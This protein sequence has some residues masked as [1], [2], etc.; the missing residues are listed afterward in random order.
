MKILAVIPVINLWNQFTEQCI[1]SIA[2]EK[3]I[4]DVMI[5]DNAS[6]DNTQ[7]KCKEML[8][9]SEMVEMI[10]DPKRN[11]FIYQRNEERWCV[12]KSW[13]YGMKYAFDNGYDFCLILNNDTI[14]N[15]KCI[16]ALVDRFEVSKYNQEKILLISGLHKLI[17]DKPREIIDYVDTNT[18]VVESEC[19]DYALFMVGREY[20]KKIGM[21]DEN[22]KPAY[23]EDADSVYRIKI[24]GY[25]RIHSPRAL[26]YHYG[27]RTHLGAEARK[28]VSDVMFLA[29]KKY[30]IDK[31]GGDIGQE[32]FIIPFN[33]TIIMEEQMFDFG[34]G[35]NILKD[36][37]R[38]CRKNW[39]GK[40]QFIQLQMPD[41]NSKMTLPYIFISTVSGDLVPWLASQTDL[42]AQDWI[43]VK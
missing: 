12:A 36:G 15:N 31:W 21:F 1:L 30:Y 23:F 16:D 42:L 34:L 32:K 5:I 22:F 10:K 13:N 43:E 17:L 20:Y 25:R 37:K 28:I 39:N 38:I 2:S 3:N 35:L 27:S 6:T 29:N 18:S 33:K 14:L 26:F 24:S 7:E 4:V 40:G 41:T 9:A 19:T 11:K 8:H